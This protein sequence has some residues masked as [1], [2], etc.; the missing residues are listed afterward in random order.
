MVRRSVLLAAAMAAALGLSQPSAAT[1]ADHIDVIVVRGNLDARA[2]SFV[3][4]AVRSSEARLVVLQVDVGAV[5]HEG[6]ES[7]I[8]VVSDPPVPLAVWVG[9]SPAAARG[10]MAVALS[11]AP[12]R[13]AAPGVRI[14][15]A[16]PMVAAGD[17]DAAAV[18]L[19]APNLPDEAL[20]GD[21]VV[22][23]APIPGL[24][25]K[26]DPSIGQFIVGLHGVEVEIGNEL[27]ELDTAISEI[28]D[29][30]ESITPAH[31]VR[32]VEPGL[33]DRVLATGTQPATTFFFLVMGLALVV[34]EFY[35]AGPGIAA[36]VAAVLLLLAGHGLVVLPVW[37][38]AVVAIVAGV[39]LYVVEFQRNDLGW[40]SILG[41]VLLLFGG[42]RFV[43][44][45]PHLE[46][47]WWV[48]AIVVLSAALFFVFALTTVARSRFAT[49]TIGRTHLVGRVGT[50]E[51]P[52]AVDGFV[53]VDGATWKAR[54]ARA[55]G[56]AKGDRVVV[57]G[58]DGIVLEVEPRR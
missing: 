14:G 9:P 16:A 55:S 50:A 57:V 13:G 1:G 6:V 18:R 42:L 17:P 43:G 23:V 58:I 22:G 8:A 4:D 36:A 7:L 3:V 38:P 56:I 26:V 15:T 10:G 34:L 53:S 37:W 25:D 44:S 51:G 32:F 54:A 46:P 21:L 2:V 29:G 20:T 47:A 5:L 27:V 12:V 48:I 45:T 24:V 28:V 49:Q 35:A 11:A 41:T 19:L 40:K 52:I 33:I 30:I 39:V 31:P